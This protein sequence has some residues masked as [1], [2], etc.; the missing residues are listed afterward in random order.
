MMGKVSGVTENLQSCE[1]V[2]HERT[3]AEWL[4]WKG[5]RSQHS[6]EETPASLVA[7]PQVEAGSGKSKVFK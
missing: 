2:I 4:T 3:E 6:S 5:L 7:L 1:F